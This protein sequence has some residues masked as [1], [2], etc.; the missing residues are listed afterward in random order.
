MRKIIIA[1]NWKMNKC[2][3]EALEFIF[4]INN[5][6]PN[7][8]KI[9]TI[10]FPQLTLLDALVQIEGENLKIGAQNIFYKKQGPYTGEI[11]PENIKS[12]GVEYV[13][14]N[15]SERKIHFGENDYIANLKLL[16]TLSYKM[17]PIVCIGENFEENDDKKE[18]TKFFLDKQIEIIFKNVDLKEVKNIII[19][20]EPTWA[21]GTEKKIIP[22]QINQIIKNIRK[23][24]S[25]LFSLKESE[26]IRIIYG[27]SIS[28]SNAESFLMQKEIDGILI[29]KNSLK[30]SDFLFFI[31]IAKNIKKIF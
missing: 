16:S 21:I 27:G 10:I 22:N 3:D 19:A 18:K 9:E 30:V 13:L 15:H 17:Y 24:I 7:K 1:G 31:K 14:I 11:S 2:K 28:S 29:G 5:K 6:I 4:K 20:Y 25:L 12:L 8:K 23:K 26:K